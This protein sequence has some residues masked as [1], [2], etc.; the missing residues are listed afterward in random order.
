MA[1]VLV[2]GQVDEGKGEALVKKVQSVVKKSGPFEFLVCLGWYE[3]DPV[4]Q[5]ILS[6]ETKLLMPLMILGGDPSK[7]TDNVTFLADSGVIKTPA[8]ILVAYQTDVALGDDISQ[9]D[10]FI[11]RETD[12][13]LAQKLSA[14]YHF[15]SSKE[16][17]E[18]SLLGA[19]RHISLPLVGSPQAEKWIYAFSMAPV[20]SQVPAK[21]KNMKILLCG[22]VQGQFETFLKRVMSVNS[23]SGPFDLLLCVG[24]F[25][26]S[27]TKEQD[28]KVDIPV[29]T[30]ILG[31][32]SAEVTHLFKDIEG[33]EMGSNLTYLGKSGILTTPTGLK[34]AYLSGIEATT[35]SPCT[36]TYG[37]L[38]RFEVECQLSVSAGVDILLTSPWP[39]DVT[40]YAADVNYEHSSG[41]VSH[42]AVALKP[43]YHFA[44]LNNVF[45]ERLP[46]RNHIV[47]QEQDRPVTRFIG[48]AAVGN[49]NKD[50]WLYALNLT[51]MCHLDLK[52]LRRQPPDV[53]E[54]P[55]KSLPAPVKESVKEEARQQFFYDMS[56][57]RGRG[58]GGKRGRDFAHEGHGG[59]RGPPQSYQKGPCWFCLSN[60][61][62]DKSLIVSIG[63]S[64]YMTLAK[65][66]LLEDHILLIP[67]DHEQSLSALC[68]ETQREVEMFKVALQ[69]FFSKQG[70]S[71]VI[72]ERN[73]RT[74]HLNLQVVP[75]P[76]SKEAKLES[77]VQDISTRYE[78]ELVQLPEFASLKQIAPQGV[79]YFYMELP[80]G[81][82]LYY[83]IQSRFPLQFGREVLAHKDV[84]DLEDR[85]DWRACEIPREVEDSLTKKFRDAFQPFDPSQSQN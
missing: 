67:I 38:K 48:L 36:F 8:G 10:M 73:Y 83:K 42:L 34:I 11:S 29:P 58:R 65:G 5:R 40:R 72:F 49:R 19:L 57:P 80:G 78:M 13:G 23:K 45:Y 43:R 22:D 71:I 17:F 75:I 70:K 68:P 74:S 15:S 77:A 12:L 33:Y 27:A 31:P 2:C 84:L 51:P 4:L 20:R 59:K 47:L 39:R 66:G 52:E 81:K 37:D 69:Q 44:A 25:F 32:N 82:R 54:S 26:A 85:V 60:A 63:E 55:Y 61:E 28:V 53:T 3:H 50:R 1:K 21:T 16:S 35:S 6:G 9:C 24:N 76:K 79:P 14:K 7:D 41:L 18:E 30:Y 64:V 56:S 62:V 46:Y